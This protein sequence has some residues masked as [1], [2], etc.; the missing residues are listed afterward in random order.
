MND[1]S[2]PPDDPLDR[3]PLDLLAEEYAARCRVDEEP[4]SA[5]EF[6]AAHPDLEAPLRDLLPAVAFLER[7]KRS[8]KASGLGTASGWL[9]VQRVD[10]GPPVR[11]LGEN[12]IV[13][14]LGRGGMGIVYEA[15]QEPLGRRVA[16]KILPPYAPGSDRSRQRFLREAQLVARLQHPH[17]VPIHAIGEHDG[18]PYFVM[19][20]VDGEGLDRLLAEPTGDVPEV[21]SA[22]RAEWVARLGQQAAEALA[23]AHSWGI[24]HRDI[25]PSNLLLDASGTLWLADFGLARLVDG[26]TLTCAGEQPGT[27]RYMA[28]ECLRDEADERSDVYSLGLTLYELAVGRPAFPESSRARLLRQIEA[29]TFPGPRELVPGLPRDLETVILKATARE[30]SARYATAGDLA[31]DLGLFRQGRPV[32]ARRATRLEHLRGWVRRNPVVAALGT[33]TAV[34]AVVTAVLVWRSL[35]PPPA[36]AAGSDAPPGAGVVAAPPGGAA[37]GPEAPVLDRGKGADV[38]PGRDHDR[39]RGR[40]FRRG[41]G[42]LPGFPPGRPP[43]PEGPPPEGLPRDP[44]PPGFRG[45]GRP[46]RGPGLR[47]EGPPP[48]FP[49]VR[50]PP[51]GDRAPSP[52]R[53]EPPV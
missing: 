4:P 29:H 52:G 9:P 37:P 43:R 6:A 26:Q 16:V 15:V 11:R 12:R 35:R 14:E 45:D 39:D 17:I 53:F 38:A 7:A 13:R 28:P 31:A 21:G 40:G 24:L 51:R 27:L 22:A 3:D 33:A 46:P 42:P 25:K 1:P 10:D 32:K 48:P 8:A 49:P 47:R 41:P 19:A 34:L 2:V 5:V 44:L 18:V 23:H 36:E 20:L 50:P 30:P